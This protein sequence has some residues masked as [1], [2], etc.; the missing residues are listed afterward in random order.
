MAIR[1]ELIR[2][3]VIVWLSFALFIVET[4]SARLA[5][6]G[7]THPSFPLDAFASPAF[8]VIYLENEPIGNQTAKNILQT[9]KQF[10]RNERENVGLTQYAK[11][12]ERMDHDGPNSPIYDGLPFQAYL[13]RSSPKSLH[14]CT[15]AKLAKHKQPLQLDDEEMQEYRSNVLR[16]ALR[17][18]APLRE[19]CIYHHQDWFSYSVCYGDSIRQFHPIPGSVG[20]GKIPT[21]DAS[22]D[23]F[24]LGRW[25]DGIESV[26]GESNDRTS[27]TIG[28]TVNEKTLLDSGIEQGSE[29]MELVHF[30]S[31]E[32]EK[33]SVR[34]KFQEG[35]PI[36]GKGRYISQSWTDGTLCDLN[37]EPRTTEV[38]YHC[39]KTPAVD[40]ISL[41]KEVT[42]CNYVIVIE[43][44]RLCTE[45]ALA[46]TEDE[47][48]EV[49]CRPILTDAELH[50]RF[51][52]NAKEAHASLLEGV[53]EDENE[54]E[55]EQEEEE[56]G[57][58]S[59]AEE[60]GASTS[61]GQRHTDHAIEE[62]KKVGS[63]VDTGTT[64]LQEQIAKIME[65]IAAVSK[66]RQGDGPVIQDVE[67]VVGMDENGEVVVDPYREGFGALTEKF[68]KATKA[69]EESKKEGN[70]ED[71][72]LP[73]DQ[74]S[75]QWTRIL[76]KVRELQ[77][78]V[79]TSDGVKYQI[80]P[81]D[82]SQTDQ[83][84]NQGQSDPTGAKT[85]SAN[86]AQGQQA[87]RRPHGQPQRG[88]T[89]IRETETFAQRVDR[90]FKAEEE[91][92]R[93][94]A[95]A[96]REE[97]DKDQEKTKKPKNWHDEL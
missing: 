22:Q 12:E 85:G 20:P 17:L 82:A 76:E 25:R 9:R 49:H 66:E 90:I 18:L 59:L 79:I 61:D 3:C 80:N 54:D 34:A 24:V 14:L 41:I 86:Q 83:A 70:E 15:L 42:T 60:K 93:H 5:K 67:L 62:K 50:E 7:S 30:S 11:Q 26:R 78:S 16:N 51:K 47:I 13:H 65:K 40:R 87:A 44:P 71:S 37:H 36:E 46:Q 33:T 19:K 72:D 21:M 4:F 52:Q 73:K 64:S 88:N 53:K 32:D 48:R 2:Y 10:V 43:T 27:A 84:N 58:P 63:N 95:N 92:E 29:L 57:N 55:E 45:P 75:D 94:K 68:L 35:S 28:D 77:G 6:P 97:D 81:D 69:R 8:K 39:A 89:M 38:Q 23:S 56:Q 96:Q 91:R 1:V 74:V 31:I